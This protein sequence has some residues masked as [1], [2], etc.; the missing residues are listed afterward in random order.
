M[1]SRT[2]F[3]TVPARN[4]ADRC[5][6]LN[7]L[8]AHPATVFGPNVAHDPP[9]HWHDVEHLVC[10]QAQLAQ[11]TSAVGA[12]A[13]TRGRLVDDLLARQMVRQAADGRWSRRYT[14]GSLGYRRIALRLQLFQ[15]QFELL[16]LTTQLLG[17]RAELHPPQPRDLPAQRIDEQIAGGKGGIG[18]GE[19]RLQRGDPRGGISRG[20]GRFRHPDSIADRLPTDEQKRRETAVPTPPVSA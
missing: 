12:G 5:G 9:A 13:G 11:G 8:L 6:R 19:R 4:G 16:D 14:G 18:P 10:V 15:R 1:A 20:N 7:D 17:R 2:K 3:L